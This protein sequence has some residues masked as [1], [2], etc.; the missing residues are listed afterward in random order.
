MRKLLH[1]VKT[2]AAIMPDFGVAKG[3]PRHPLYADG[4]GSRSCDAGLRAIGAVPFR[5]VRR[6]RREGTRDPHRRCK[7]KTDLFGELRARARPPRAVQAAARRG[8]KTFKREAGRMH[9]PAAAAAIMRAHRGARPRLGEPAA[10]GDLGEKIRR[11][12]PVL[13]TDP[14]YILYT[15][16]TTGIPRAWCATMAGIWS[17]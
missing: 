1:E 13:A 17:R 9:H 2:L 16:G 3:D 12:R 5:G 7:T 8:D 14:L 10:Q 11:L 4:A 15:S 6:L